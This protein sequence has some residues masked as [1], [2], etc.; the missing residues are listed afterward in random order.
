MAPP[1]SIPW[2]VFNLT[3]DEPASVVSLVFFSVSLAILVICFLWALMLVVFKHSHSA[4]KSKQPIQVL[5]SF[6]AC[7][8]WY[9]GYAYSVSL[10]PQ[11]PHLC[12]VFVWPQQLGISFFTSFVATRQIVLLII[13]YVPSAM[14]F[15]RRKNIN[16]SVLQLLQV[17]LNI[18][19]LL[20]CIVASVGSWVRYSDL[21]CRYTP[22]GVIIVHCIVIPII[23]MVFVLGMLTIRIRKE[24]REIRIYIILSIIMVLYSS[25]L[26]ILWFLQL[27]HHTAT[28]IVMSFCPFVMGMYFLFATLGE[29]M[30]R[31]LACQ[32]QWFDKWIDKYHKNTQLSLARGR[33]PKISRTSKGEEGEGEE[34]M[35]GHQVEMNESPENEQQQERESN[36]KISEESSSQTELE[37]Q[38]STPV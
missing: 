18:P 19:L 8:M 35:Q 6:F 5:L 34:E 11:S 23:F 13:F 2:N 25:L 17:V 28:R 36:I 31:F 12:I 29:C 15:F 26:L 10:V 37:N 22:A 16:P 24:F 30:L 4:V 1:F 21:H 14:N 20:Y 27:I 32:H 3:E 33:Q 9:I 38:H 7:I